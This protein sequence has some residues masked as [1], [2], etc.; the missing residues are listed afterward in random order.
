MYGVFAVSEA[1]ERKRVL[2]QQL[3]KI[4]SEKRERRRGKLQNYLVLP[5]TFS[6]KIFQSSVDKHQVRRSPVFRACIGS[7][8]PAVKQYHQREMIEEFLQPKKFELR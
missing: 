5:I 1:E 8:S 7:K 4:E 6:L 2:R 3:T